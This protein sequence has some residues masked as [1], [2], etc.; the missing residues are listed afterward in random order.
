LGNGDLGV[1]V[2]PLPFGAGPFG[3]GPL[4]AGAL[5]GPPFHGQ[6]SLSSPPLPLAGGCHPGGLVGVCLGAP[7][8]LGGVGFEGVGAFGAGFGG[9]ICFGAGVGLTG[10]GGAGAGAEVGACL[11]GAGAFGG[12]TE[13]VDTGAAVLGFGAGGGTA[14]GPWKLSGFTGTLGLLE[15]GA[16]TGR[17]G[18]AGTGGG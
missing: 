3:A 18:P 8:G 9:E 5:G 2:G 10:L 11:G 6:E 16:L 4:G 15:P 7:L 14:G 1:G 13:D 17:G 12:A